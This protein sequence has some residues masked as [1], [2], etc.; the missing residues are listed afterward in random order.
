MCVCV[1]T[2]NIHVCVLFPIL[3]WFRTVRSV[4]LVVVIVVVVE[5]KRGVKCTSDGTV[6]LLERVR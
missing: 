6:N 4:V 2:Y 3:F 1:Y 5:G